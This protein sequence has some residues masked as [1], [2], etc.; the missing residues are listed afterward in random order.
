MNSFA[1]INCD[2]AYAITNP[3][4]TARSH[5]LPGR[6][7]EL[8]AMAR[9]RGNIGPFGLAASFGTMQSGVIHAAD[10]ATASGKIE[11][12]VPLKR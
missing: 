5:N 2:R 8:Q 7:N 4:G 6:L 10:P 12:W 11:L 3:Q 1:S 9:W